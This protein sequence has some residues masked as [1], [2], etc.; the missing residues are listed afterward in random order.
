MVS[1]LPSFSQLLASLYYFVQFRV[2]LALEA[3]L[4][5]TGPHGLL[6]SSSISRS[7]F[8]PIPLGLY[9]CP[10]RLGSSWLYVI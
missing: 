9:L 2:L 1:L 10:I 3:R 5:R 7:Q 8:G 4:R 6:W